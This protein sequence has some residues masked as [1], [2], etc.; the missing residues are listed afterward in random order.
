VITADAYL[1]GEAYSLGGA[2]L[3]GE[4]NPGGWLAAAI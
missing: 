4:G 2:Y 3:P 1:S